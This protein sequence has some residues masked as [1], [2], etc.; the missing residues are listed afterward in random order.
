ME[1][2]KELKLA[3]KDSLRT[4]V[5]YQIKNTINGKI[6]IEGSVNLHGSLNSQR[7]QLKYKIHRDKILQED[8]D[9]YSPDT[10]TFDILETIKTDEVP[11]EEWREKI[12]AL[13]EKWLDILKPYGESGYNE[14]KKKR[15]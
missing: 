7:F 15:G 12:L 5:V 8:W 11:K 3:Y 10:F 13:K 9:T 6:F 4:M 14:I 2:R 1:K